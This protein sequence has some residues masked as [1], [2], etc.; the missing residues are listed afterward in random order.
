MTQADK[1]NKKTTS[2]GWF[3]KLMMGA[4][5]LVLC[6]LAVIGMLR[7]VHA[8]WPTSYGLAALAVG[9]LVYTLLSP[10]VRKS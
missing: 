2:I 6:F 4:A 5:F 7:F 3:D 1:T 9:F 8:T 10:L